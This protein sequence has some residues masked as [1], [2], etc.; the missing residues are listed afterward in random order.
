MKGKDLLKSQRLLSVGDQL[1]F[2][3]YLANSEKQLHG[4]TESDGYDSYSRHEYDEESTDDEYHPITS[5]T[6]ESL[7]L[8]IVVDV[9]GNM[10]ITDLDTE[11]DNI[12]PSESY[13]DRD[14]DDHEY[15]RY[16]GNCTHWFRDTVLFLIPMSTLQTS[17]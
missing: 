13:E 12:L 17:S 9:H 3:L 8:N 15:D 1:E 6:E 16:E 5:V 4:Y 7:K 11:E 14:P 10:I 2:I